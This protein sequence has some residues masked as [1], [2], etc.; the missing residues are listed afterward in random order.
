MRSAAASTAA[1]INNVRVQ[2]RT[3][4]TR[5]K[6]I[7]AGLHE[8]GL[9]GFEASST[10]SIASRAGVAQSALPYHFT[11]KDELWRAAAEKIF[12][13]FLTR[14]GTILEMSSDD[15]PRARAESL[16]TEAVCFFAQHPEL[17]RFMT[18]ETS[19]PRVEWLVET[20]IRPLHS[21]F[22]SLI[23]DLDA[24][25]DGAAPDR[26]HLFYMFVGAAAAPYEMAYEYNAVNGASP[27]DAEA[28]NRHAQSMIRT[29]LP[30]A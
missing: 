18:D 11:T 27:F 3:L 16:I 9:N 24:P 8:F 5:Q 20:H 4:R 7:A 21:V 28:V 25:F 17:H 29:F 26:Q 30:P 14:F 10:R 13:E 19:G 6:L 2:E 1:D 23:A 15:E 22:D 12:G